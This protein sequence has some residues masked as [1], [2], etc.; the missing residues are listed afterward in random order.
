VAESA[1]II[2]LPTPKVETQDQR[3]YWWDELEKAERR[4]EDIRRMLGILA[5]ERGLSEGGDGAA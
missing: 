4:A 5:V 2:Y 1:D 3:N